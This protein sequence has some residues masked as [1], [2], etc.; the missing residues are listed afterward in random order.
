MESTT[1]TIAQRIAARGIVCIAVE[2]MH[3]KQ[4]KAAVTLS[5]AKA[6]VVENLRK[7]ASYLRGNA[8]ALNN[9]EGKVNEKQKCFKEIAGRYSVGAKYNIR[10]LKDVYEAGKNYC[11]VTSATA[12]ADVCDT[13]VEAVSAGLLDEQVLAAMEANKNMRKKQ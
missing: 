13:L 11:E 1:Q 8:S 10:Y 5:A 3:V 6:E 12:A 7:N 2:K 9:K 4:V